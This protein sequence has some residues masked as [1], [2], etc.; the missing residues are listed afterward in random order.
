MNYQEQR[1]AAFHG[2]LERLAR[3]AGLPTVDA[4]ALAER[5]AATPALAVLFTG[6]PTHSPES[7]DVCVVLPE[8]LALC[9][10]LAACVLDPAESAIAAP[11][12]GVGKLPALVLLRDGEYVGVIE[13]MRDWQPFRDELRRLLVAPP[14]PIPVAGI[15]AATQHNARSV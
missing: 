2:L 7:W 6:E 1:A 15:Y 14:R 9:P 13:G 5:T 12:Y 11:A 10:G 8:L 4:A 3:E